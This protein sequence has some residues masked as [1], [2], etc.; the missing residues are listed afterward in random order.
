MALAC[1]GAALAQI[2]PK[3]K[4]VHTAE[5]QQM[6]V[7]AM[8]SALCLVRFEYQLE[9]TTSHEKFNAEGKDYFGTSEGFLVKAEGGWMAPAG[10]ATPWLGDQSVKQYPGYKPVISSATIMMPGDT[11]F[12]ELPV[13]EIKKRTPVPMS[14]FTVVEDPGTFAEG[15]PFGKREGTV[16]GYVVWLSKKGNG[17][18]VTSYSHNLAASDSSFVSLA[19]KAVPEGAVGGVYVAPSYPSAGTIRF[20]LLGVLENSVNGWQIVKTGSQM[21]TPELS[22]DKPKLVPA[23]KKK[24][25]AAATKDKKNKK[26][27]TR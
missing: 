27:N 19:G 18:T 8:K 5:N 15:L 3:L 6:V 22:A 20:E 12:R 10:T 21:E 14:S 7:S 13:P 26:N 2:F 11:V 24:A 17:L 4:P 23:G 25:E 1:Q 9:D 16:E